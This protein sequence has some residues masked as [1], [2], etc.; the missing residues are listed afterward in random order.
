MLLALAARLPS[1]AVAQE[2]SPDTST[3]PGVLR[4]FHVFDMHLEMAAADFATI[5]DDLTNEIEVPAMFSVPGEAPIKVSVRR[6][7]SRTAPAAPNKFSMKVDI[8]EFEDE[9]AARSAGTG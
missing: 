6:K 8:N 2:P 7:S 1:P 5:R 3:W 9:P 4:P